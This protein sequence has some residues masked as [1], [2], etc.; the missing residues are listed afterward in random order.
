MMK[1]KYEKTNNAGYTGDNIKT[2]LRGALAAAL[3]MAFALLLAPTTAQAQTT[4]YLESDIFS[5]SSSEVV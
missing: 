2:Y 4:A 3:I 1:T 5:T